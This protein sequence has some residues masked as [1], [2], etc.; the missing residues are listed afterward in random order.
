MTICFNCQKEGY[1]PIHI[2]D[3]DFVC[4]EKC[5][6]EFENRR[7]NFLNN[8]VHSETEV[9]LYLIGGMYEND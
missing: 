1:N 5:R 9:I 7:D 8:I 2:G 6:I 3:S 4:S